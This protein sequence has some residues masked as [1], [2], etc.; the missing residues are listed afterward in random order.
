MRC[1]ALEFNFTLI[2]RAESE[3]LDP[4]AP[5]SMYINP[6]FQWEEVLLIFMPIFPTVGWAEK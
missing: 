3:S 4:K 5:M 2:L 6:I 1:C